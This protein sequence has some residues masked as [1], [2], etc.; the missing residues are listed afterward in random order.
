MDAR[1]DFPL[2][3]NGSELVYFDNACQTLRPRQVIDAIVAYYEEYPACGGR[4]LHKMGSHVSNLV[5]KAREATASFVGAGESAEIVFTKNTTEG[6]N[7]VAQAIPWEKGDVVV[8]TD[9]E[10]NSNNLPWLR[11]AGLKG[12]RVVRV[13]SRK[14]GTFDLAQYEKALAAHRKE[15]RLVSMGWASNADGVTIPAEEIVPRAH[16]LDA[17]VMLDAA[18]AVPHRPVD[19]GALDVDFLAFSFHKMLGPSGMGALYGR[20]DLLETLTPLSL[21]GGTAASVSYD[22]YELLG[23]PDKWEAGLQDYAGILGSGAAVDYLRPRIADVPAHDAKLNRIITEGLDVEGVTVHGPAPESRG[24]IVPFTVDGLGPH[25]VALALD[26]RDVAIRSGVHCVHAWY[27]KRGAKDGWARA[28][29]YLYNTE[30]EAKRFVRAVASIANS[31][32][33]AKAR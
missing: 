9:K 12:I 1:R 23:A 17:L 24:G 15:V 5:Q 29:T 26:E 11:L 22:D 6:L 2:L 4:S 25:D 32:R 33:V 28:S 20:R 3:A 19:V 7:L 10:H 18:Q 16:E 31:V 30:D 21:G 14:D 8:T 27:A 13:P